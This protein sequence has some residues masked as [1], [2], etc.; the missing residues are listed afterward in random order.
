MDIVYRYADVNCQGHTMSTWQGEVNLNERVRFHRIRKY[1][2]V[3]KLNTIE[4]NVQTSC[5]LS[6]TTEIFHN[7][8]HPLQM[9]G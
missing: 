5:C 6:V 3:L 1:L 8:C 7:F 9:H 2:F 4:Q